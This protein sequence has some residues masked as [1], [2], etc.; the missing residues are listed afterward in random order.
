M[1]PLQLLVL[2]MVVAGDR[3]YAAA[4]DR[5]EAGSVRF[6]KQQLTDRY[7]CDGITAGDIN[8]DEQ[9]DVVAG[10]FWY[11]GPQFERAHAFYEAVPLVPEA[12]PSNS[13]FSFVHDFNG[14]GR[15]DI[16][17]LGR[18]HLHPAQWY[19]NPGDS[20]ELWIPH[21]AFERVRGESPAFVDLDGDGVPQ[22]ICHWDGR[23]GTISPNVD[24]PTEPWGFQA[25]GENEEW[26]QF[27]H[28]EG[29]GD[30][31]NDGH[32]DLIINDGW[33]EQPTTADGDWTYQRGRFSL[34]KGGAQM[35]VD[36]VDDDGDQDVITALHAHEW[37]L[38]WFE[39]IDPSTADAAADRHIGNTW[40][41]EHIIMDDREHEAEYGAAF[42]QPHAVGLADIDGN[43]HRD[44]VVGKRM[45]A[46]G[47]T[48]DKE[49]NADPVV[50]WFQHTVRPDGSVHYEPRLIDRASGVGTQITIADVNN[51]GR[52]DVLTSS[53][54]GAFVFINRSTSE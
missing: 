11:E 35:F 52:V 25:V 51:D 50:Y 29:V 54:L 12:S 28:G 45:W 5:P 27:Y 40:F 26:P 32:L 6:E 37:G 30:V 34:R 9:T 4:E 42:S 1:R 23:W 38:A 33:Y 22:L 46:H 49:P 20:D 16:L 47:P 19:E 53:K 24:Q 41:R 36:D 44:I 15:N 3:E 48:R 10:P 17:V 43:G 21:F 8:G 39:Q 31:N 7:Y 14:D 13:M 2:L 18:V